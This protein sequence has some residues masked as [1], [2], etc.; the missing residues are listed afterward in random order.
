M[1][2]K[3]SKTNPYGLTPK[4]RLTV[5]DVVEGVKDGKGVNLTASHARYYQTSSDNSAAVI[6]NKNMKRDNFRQALVAGLK[7]KKVIGANSK[8]EQRLSE[9]LDAE[10]DDGLDRK[11]ILEY[12]KEINKVSGAYA[13]QR[14]ESK[15]L[16]LNIS[17][18]QLD[19]KIEQL[20][21]ELG[22][23]ENEI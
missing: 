13:P 19:D 11:T 22:G 8:V 18:K 7:E 15:S 21:Q 23:E 12:I 1:K 16:H 9:G 20:Q 17:G 5:E 4:Q 6:A 14:S 10:N 2:P 3:K